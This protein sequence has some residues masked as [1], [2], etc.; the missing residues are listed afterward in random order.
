[1]YTCTSTKT[2][3]HNFMEVFFPRTTFLEIYVWK[4]NH[5]FCLVNSKKN[6]CRCLKMRQFSNFGSLNCTIVCKNRWRL[7]SCAG[8]KFTLVQYIWKFATLADSS[9]PPLLTMATMFHFF[10]TRVLIN[11]HRVGNFRRL[12]IFYVYTINVDYW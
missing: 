12:L 4:C 1:M 11:S 2:T 10:S 6:S 8:G 3:Y 7:R 9:P 5:G